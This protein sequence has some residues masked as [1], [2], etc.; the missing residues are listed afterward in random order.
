MSD[1]ITIRPGLPDE[2]HLL[3][4]F[5]RAATVHPTV[6]DNAEGVDTLFAQL[7]ATALLAL[8]EDRV[9]G[10]VIAAFDGWRGNIYRLAVAP[11]FK[12]QGIAKRLV[13]EAERRLVARGAKRLVAIVDSESPESV[14]FWDA[15]ATQGWTASHPG[16]RYVKSL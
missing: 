6:T 1:E 16:V 12:R 5:W 4:D 9:V 15:M 2:S 7:A 8:A 3:L 14:P 11:E 13:A 10:S